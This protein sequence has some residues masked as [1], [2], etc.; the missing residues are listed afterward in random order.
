MEHLH[1]AVLV[2]VPFELFVS[3]MDRQTRIITHISFFVNIRIEHV[4]IQLISTY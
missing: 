1:L 4:T 3:N 2:A